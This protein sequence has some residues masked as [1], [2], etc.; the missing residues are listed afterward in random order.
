[1]REAAL[2][3]D[4]ALEALLSELDP[5]QGDEGHARDMAALA[6]RR[7]RSRAAARAA[8]RGELPPE[9]AAEVGELIEIAQRIL[10]RRRVLRGG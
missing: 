10:R 8:P 9:L 2:Q 7:E 5:S 4:A 3:L 1:M 6:E